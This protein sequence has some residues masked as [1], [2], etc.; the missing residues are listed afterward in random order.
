MKTPK[1]GSTPGEVLAV[2]VTRSSKPGFD[3]ALEGKAL[4]SSGEDAK[5]KSQ[6]CLDLVCRP[7]AQPPAQAS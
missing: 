6:K 3:E 5:T 4:A 2:A 7:V 1:S